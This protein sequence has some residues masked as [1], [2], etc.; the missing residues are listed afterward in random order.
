MMKEK[1]FDNIF[2]QF[3]KGKKLERYDQ[4]KELEQV[5][6]KVMLQDELFEKEK[7]KML[8]NK[9]KS[10]QDKQQKFNSF[11]EAARLRESHASQG[12]S[13]LRGK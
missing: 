5:K 13:V 8:T 1:I 2:S 12:S 11:K 9:K 7:Q 4:L 3:S 6:E 10:E